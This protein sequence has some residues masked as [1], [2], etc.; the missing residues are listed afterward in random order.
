MCTP[1]EG[2]EGQREGQLP[3]TNDDL[4]TNI[5]YHDDTR[6]SSKAHLDK[7]TA[8]VLMPSVLLQ[9]GTILII[10]VGAQGNTHYGAGAA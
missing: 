1:T 5:S 3:V 6:G 10:S 9:V 8:L 7:M 4:Y 2:W